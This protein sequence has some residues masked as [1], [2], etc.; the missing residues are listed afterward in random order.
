MSTSS[1]VHSVPFESKDSP[2][3]KRHKAD[4]SHV[5]HLEESDYDPAF[6]TTGGPAHSPKGEKSTQQQAEH[7][8][9]KQEKFEPKAAEHGK[10]RSSDAF[11]ASLALKPALSFG[12]HSPSQEPIWICNRDDKVI[13]VYKVI[14]LIH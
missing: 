11:F 5:G 12:V 6:D 7:L 3:E 13:D 1:I 8:M 4:S 2:N 10:Y 9:N 14:Q